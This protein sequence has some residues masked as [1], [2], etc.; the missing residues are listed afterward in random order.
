MYRASPADILIAHIVFDMMFEDQKIYPTV[1]L[2][3]SKN[4][5][6]EGGVVADV[7]LVGVAG[8]LFLIA[9]LSALTFNKR[10]SDSTTAFLRSLRVRGL[11]KYWSIVIITPVRF[12]KNCSLS[13]RH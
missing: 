8:D 10:Q 13:N 1:F 4:V 11:P 7:V 6:P 9:V 12:A 3:R 2:A 5:S